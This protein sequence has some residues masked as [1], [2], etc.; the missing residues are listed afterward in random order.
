MGSDQKRNIMVTWT[1]MVA[2][3]VTVAE[4]SNANK[5]QKNPHTPQ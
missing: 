1:K 2:G 5:T 4:E 3:E